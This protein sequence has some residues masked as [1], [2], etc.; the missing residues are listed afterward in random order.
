M[1]SNNPTP[2]IVIQTRMDIRILA[3]LLT[4]YKEAKRFQIPS[5]SAFISAILKEQ[6]DALM[7]AGFLKPG[8]TYEEAVTICA[9]TD[10][11]N[12]SDS[13]NEALIAAISDERRITTRATAQLPAR[14]RHPQHIRHKNASTAQRMD[15]W[16]KDRMKAGSQRASEPQATE[17]DE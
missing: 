5:R 7:H 16:A 1:T 17:G 6:H 3:A 8:T 9:E 10:I 11:L 4:H 2:T 15:D 13:T 12:M 14:T